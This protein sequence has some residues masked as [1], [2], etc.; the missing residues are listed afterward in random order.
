MGFKPSQIFPLLFAASAVIFF[1]GTMLLTIASRGELF[2]SPDETAN[3]FFARQF[4]QSGTLRIFDPLNEQF[5]HALYPRSV[6]AMSGFL[7]PQSFV[8]LPVLYGFFAFLFGPEIL[9]ILTPLLAILAGLALRSILREWFSLA[10]AHLSALLFLFH[11]ALWYYSARG[12]MHNVLFV[13]LLIFGAYLF[14]RRPITRHLHKHLD[15]FVAGAMIGLAIFVRAS[16]VYWIAFLLLFVLCLHLKR[17]WKDVLR[18]FVGVLIGVLPFFWLNAVT[19]G[20]PLMTGYTVT[21][22]V[23]ASSSPSVFDAPSTPWIFPFGID[24]RSAG[25]HVVDYGLSLF[26]WLSLLALIGFPIVASRRKWYAFA[27]FAVALWLGLWYGSWTFFD[28]PDRS[29]IT[30]ANSYVRYWLPVFVLSLPLI[31]EGILWL[32]DRARTLLARKLCVSALMILVIGLNVRLVFFD[33]Q[34]SLIRMSRVL[35]EAQTTKMDVLTRTE[36]NA[37]I[38][39]D[40][41][42]K[43]FFPDRHVRYP[44]RSD[45]TYALMPRLVESV[46][47]YYFG[48]TLPEKDMRYLNESKLLESGLSIEYLQTYGEESLYRIEKKK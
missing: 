40:R 26:W 47:V 41:A 14:V 3:A 12:L 36:P 30:I 21:A 20:H 4:S 28:N 37:V 19:Y 2:V 34:D 32:S 13:C 9:F 31:A 25:A 16:E 39:V 8:G 48:I 45:E 18:F 11:P 22:P 15:E 43:L 46:P 17:G 6:V 42:D 35:S 23:A 38:I 7:L 29:Q 24:V 27:F 44:L 10:T 5:E 1:A 33:G